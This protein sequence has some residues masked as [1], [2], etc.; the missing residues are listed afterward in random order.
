MGSDD[1]RAQFERRIREVLA[2]RLD[3]LGARAVAERRALE[4]PPAGLRDEAGD[5]G[6]Q[7]GR[8]EPRDFGIRMSEREAELAQ[9]IEA[10]LQRLDAGQYGVCLECGQCIEPRRLELVPWTPYCADDAER[11]ERERAPVHTTL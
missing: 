3:E 8:D 9:Q 11:L 10:A 4:T 7:S 2:R 6:D 5:E 1:G